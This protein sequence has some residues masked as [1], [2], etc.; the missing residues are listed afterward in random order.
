[1]PCPAMQFLN[2]CRGAVRPVGWNA[3]PVGPA[4]LANPAA[5]H[6]DD[7]LRGAAEH[8]VLCRPA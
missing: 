1:M 8:H 6:W 5:V 3:S 7:P 2:Y 4:H